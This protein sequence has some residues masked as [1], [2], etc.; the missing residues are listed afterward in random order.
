MAPFREFWKSKD[1]VPW[2]NNADPG[3]S[4]SIFQYEALLG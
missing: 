2:I 1:P 4:V 3:I